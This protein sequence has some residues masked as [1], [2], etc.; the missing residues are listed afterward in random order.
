[1]EVGD[2]VGEELSFAFVK[3]GGEVDVEFGGGVV[4]GVGKLLGELNNVGC[5]VSGEALESSEEVWSD[6]ISKGGWRGLD[7]VGGFVVG[8][9]GVGWMLRR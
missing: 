5:T 8:C 7:I 3:S 4:G 2:G 1:M 9:F 6:G